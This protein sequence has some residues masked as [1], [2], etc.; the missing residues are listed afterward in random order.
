LPDENVGF[1]IAL[2]QRRDCVVFHADL[3]PEEFILALEALYIGCRD[4][5]GLVAAKRTSSM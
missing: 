2:Q 3:S 4:R 5:S 1:P